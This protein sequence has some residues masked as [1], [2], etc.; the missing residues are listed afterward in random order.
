MGV[1]IQDLKLPE[2]LQRFELFNVYRRPS[3]E[4]E[5]IYFSPYFTQASK[6]RRGIQHLAHVRGVIRF[7][8]KNLARYEQQIRNLS[9]NAELVDG[10]IKGVKLG[11]NVDEELSHYF[12][13]AM[14]VRFENSVM[15]D[16]NDDPNRGAGWISRMIPV[17]R[18]V[19]LQEFS[20]RYQRANGAILEI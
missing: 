18:I 8:P 4:C 11:N 2:E 9:D 13:E 19:S 14:P 16:R 10:W 3:V 20:R 15:K 1:L 7:A 17:N 6:R 5:P 12:L